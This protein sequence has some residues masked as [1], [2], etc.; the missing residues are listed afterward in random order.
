MTIHT[1]IREARA[2]LANARRAQ[3][4]TYRDQVAADAAGDG[5][6]FRDASRRAADANRDAAQARTRIHELRSLERLLRED[7]ALVEAAIAELERETTEREED[8]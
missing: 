5:V 4:V 2:D 7:L 8:R 6:A 1:E 3:G